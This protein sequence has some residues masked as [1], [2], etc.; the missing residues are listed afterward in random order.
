MTY[1]FGN[2]ALLFCLYDQ[3]W[4]DPPRC[5]SSHSIA[6]GVLTCI[7]ASWRAAQ[8]M[9][10]YIDSGDAFPH[11]ANFVKYCCNIATYAMLSVWRINKTHPVRD[12]FILFATINSTYCSIWDVAID[13]SLGN[14]KG[15]STPNRH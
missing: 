6:L 1:V 11:I 10:R 7:P 15:Q 9:R 14:R 3:K 12:T 13:W 8:T 4:S 5:N 2:I